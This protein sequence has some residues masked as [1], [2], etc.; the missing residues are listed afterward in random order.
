MPQTGTSFLKIV[1]NRVVANV[2]F[3]KISPPLMHLEFA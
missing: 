3:D 1:H 2:S